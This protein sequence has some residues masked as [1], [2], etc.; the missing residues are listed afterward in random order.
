MIGR[1]RLNA[2]L[3]ALYIQAAF[4]IVATFIFNGLDFLNIMVYNLVTYPIIFVGA[5]RLML[6]RTRKEAE[7][8]E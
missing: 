6:W 2:L 7:D 1:I 8:E 4:I 5:Y 3:F